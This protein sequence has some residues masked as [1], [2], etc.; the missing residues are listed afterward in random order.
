[1]SV[2][3]IFTNLPT[4]ASAQLTDIICA[5]QGYSSPT[6]LGTSVQETLGQVIALANS[7]I[8]VTNAGNPNGF[9]A[10]TQYQTLCWDTVDSLLW[11]CTLTGSSSTSTWAPVSSSGLGLFWTTIAGDA[12]ISNST[13]YVCNSASL[14]TLTLPVTASV[15]ATFSVVN[16]NTGGFIITQNASQN[17]RVGT[18][19]TTTGLGGSIAS[20]ARGDA[21]T[22]IC[23]VANTTW[24]VAS[25]PQGIF[26]VV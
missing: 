18:A 2:S 11:I 12:N 25:A 4:V 8:I 6:V 3:E 5:V 26:T 7:N 23:V 24:S 9:V 16:Y 15:G 10:G 19:L 1:M 21:I 13:G 22:L 14:I 20:T 17:I